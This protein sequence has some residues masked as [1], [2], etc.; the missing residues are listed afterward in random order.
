MRRAVRLAKALASLLAIEIFV[1]GGTLLVLTLLWAGR[2]GTPLP[3]FLG[4]RV[5]ALSRVFAR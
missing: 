4:R 1:P 5:Q 2:P 3:G